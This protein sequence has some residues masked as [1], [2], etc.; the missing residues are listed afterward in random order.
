MDQNRL[1][2][3]C[4]IALES[5]GV[6]ITE[7]RALPTHSFD[8]EKGEWVPGSYSLFFGVKRKMEPVLEKVGGDVT[9]RQLS[10]EFGDLERFLESLLGFECVVD[11]D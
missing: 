10:S 3:I 5:R 11:F 8:H 7:F 6:S 1:K 2:K 9:Y 4:E